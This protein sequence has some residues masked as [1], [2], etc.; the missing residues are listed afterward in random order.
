MC[1]IMWI[2][3]K[4]VKSLALY[5][6]QQ[7]TLSIFFLNRPTSYSKI[8]DPSGTVNVFLIQ[9]LTVPLVQKVWAHHWSQLWHPCNYT[10]AKLPVQTAAW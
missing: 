9:N 7:I 6:K 8:I 4:N 2:H 10:N 1:E 3:L 5:K